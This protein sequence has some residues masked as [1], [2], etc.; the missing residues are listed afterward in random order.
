MSDEEEDD[1]DEEVGVRTLPDLCCAD[2]RTAG[3][4]EVQG[5]SHVRGDSQEQNA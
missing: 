2:P 1:D 4:E 5:G 3:T